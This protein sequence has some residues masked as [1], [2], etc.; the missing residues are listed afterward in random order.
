MAG[1]RQGA[2]K[3]VSERDGGVITVICRVQL[4]ITVKRDITLT[5]SVVAQRPT[6]CGAETL[7]LCPDERGNR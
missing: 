3:C 5:C 2:T 4:D 7:M 6:V 1:L